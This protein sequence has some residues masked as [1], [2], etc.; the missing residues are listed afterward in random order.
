MFLH[1]LIFSIPALIAIGLITLYLNYKYSGVG[2]KPL[3]MAFFLGVFSVVPVFIIQYLIEAAGFVLVTSLK[4]MLFY[5]FFVE[6]FVP[7]IVVLSVLMSFFYRQVKFRTTADGILYSLYITLGL[8]VFLIPL[9]LSQEVFSKHELL[10]QLAYLPCLMVSAIALGFFSGLSRQ[11]KNTF[12]D[13]MT[14]LMAADFF[15]G[16]Y[17]FC[18]LT[19]ETML[20]IISGL[21][22]AVISLLF[23]Y[24]A[25]TTHKSEQK[26]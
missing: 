12:V 20:W 6:G 17:I 22:S 8:S 26:I 23:I 21:A 13:L 4:R 10:F 2:L 11:R 25:V 18:M 5:S 14:G 16:L 15:Q 19:N 24:K 7:Q 9:T 3:F 1:N